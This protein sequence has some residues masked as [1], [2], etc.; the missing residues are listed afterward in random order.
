MEVGDPEVRVCFDGE[1]EAVG[2]ADD[3]HAGFALWE[4][5]GE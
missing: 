1:G 3:L 2:S 4:C 5:G